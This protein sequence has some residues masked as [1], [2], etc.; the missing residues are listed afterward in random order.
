MLT[1]QEVGF[2]SVMNFDSDNCFMKISYSHLSV[3]IQWIL[4]RPFLSHDLE[5]VGI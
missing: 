3:D 2:L 1:I 4:M 5:N